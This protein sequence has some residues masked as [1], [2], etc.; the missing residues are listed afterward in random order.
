MLM[1]LGQDNGTTAAVEATTIPVATKT[2]PMAS[3]NG[4][5]PNAVHPHGMRPGVGKWAPLFVIGALGFFAGMAYA[6]R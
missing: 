6:R 5:H 3:E 1:G 4:Q 2:P